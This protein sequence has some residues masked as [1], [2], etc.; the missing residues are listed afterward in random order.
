MT[1][2][3]QQSA[4]LACLVALLVGGFSPEL[5]AQAVARPGVLLGGGDAPAKVDPTL[6]PLL[7]T[8]ARVQTQPRPPKP[9]LSYCGLHEPVCVH[10]ASGVSSELAQRYLEALEDARARLV[11]ALGLPAPLHDHEGP[12]SGLDFYLLPDAPSPFAVVAD[13]RWLATDRTSGHCR[14]RPAPEEVRRQASLCVA[15]AILLGL[16]AAEAPH[17]RRAIAGYL[18]NASGGA[19]NADWLAIDDWQSNPQLALAGR[20]V[21][22]DSTGAALFLRYLDR[23]LGANRL[24]N[25][26]AALVQMSR[27]DTPAD[28]TLWINEPDSIDVLRRSFADS[29]ESFDDFLLNFAVARAFLGSR[30]NGHHD[31]A[32]LWLGDAGRV[33]FDWNIK[34]SSLPRNLAPRRA[35]EPF[36]STYLWLELDRVT[37]GATLAFQANWEAPA[38]FRWT[39]VAVD[40]FGNALKRYDL[41]YVQQATSAERTLV[42]HDGAVAFLIVG[43]SV[44]GVD[45]AHPFD[46]D[47]EPFEPHGYTV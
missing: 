47:H 32:L 46:P 1:R 23:R 26:P 24:G 38:V 37:P 5:A 34:A 27:V 31:P 35:I 7:P 41:P 11:G 15:E 39:L 14:A 28:R 17:L 42:D 36:G 16:D 13:P 40:A 6:D 43:I 8:G 45:L 10:A 33:R 21:A 3:P 19:S 12:S 20:E 44:A 18:W 30:D 29:P 25:L 2:R 4:P 9:S 22:R